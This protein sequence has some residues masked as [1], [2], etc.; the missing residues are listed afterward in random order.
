[1]SG[2]VNISL[3][4]GAQLSSVSIAVASQL[5]TRRKAAGHSLDELAKRAGVSKGILVEI[6]KGTANPSI[7]ILCKVASA[8]GVSVADIVNVADTPNMH[9]IEAA[10][11]PTLW[12][13]PRG[14]SARLLAGTT[15]RDMVELWRWEME[16]GE[17]FEATAHSRGTFE[18]LYVEQGQLTLW[19]DSEELTVACGCSVVAQTDVPHRYAND[20]DSRLVF[21]MTVAELSQSG[22]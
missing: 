9:V 13:G 15:G 22:R 14:G 3:K 18:M 19:R 8:L 12:T 4:A 6:E 2:K 5:K 1:M 20:G 16:P 17:S 10:Q 7:A 21:T 11:M